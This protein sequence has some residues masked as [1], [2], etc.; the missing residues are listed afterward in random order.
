MS[1]AS[2]IEEFRAMISRIVDTLE[3][4]S[5]SSKTVPGTEVEQLSQKFASL[6]DGLDD[7]STQLNT[8]VDM[9]GDIRSRW[10]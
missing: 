4:V 5:A 7:I 8:C 3:E 9:L 10:G 1:L 2:D 6:D